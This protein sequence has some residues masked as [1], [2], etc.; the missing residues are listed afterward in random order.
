MTEQTTKW[1]K[2]FLLSAFDFFAF[3][4]FILGILLFVRFFILNIYNVIWLSMAPTFADRDFIV[5]EKITSNLW[6]LDRGD[7]IIF[8][9]DGQDKPYVKR[10]IWLPGETV[11]IVDWKVDICVDNECE[12]LQEDYLPENIETTAYCSV[13]EFEIVD[14]FFVLWDNRWHSTDSRC[15][16]NSIWCYENSSYEVGSD[17]IIG[18]VVLRLFPNPWTF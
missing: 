6:A 13:D 18:K 9:P 10:I 5:V 15:C 17:D 8:M 2:G 3:A 1:F 16:F 12:E 14:W 11:K 7:V 4:V